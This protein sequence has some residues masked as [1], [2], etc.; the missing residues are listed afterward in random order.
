MVIVSTIKLCKLAPILAIQLNKIVEKPYSHKATKA[1]YK[2]PIESPTN[3]FSE[4]KVKSILG[5]MK[6]GKVK[7]N[8]NI[9]LII[10]I[11]LSVGMISSIFF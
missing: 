5:K 2:G 8:I 7:R 4:I 9:L 11:R 3:P 1:T 6:V 10:I